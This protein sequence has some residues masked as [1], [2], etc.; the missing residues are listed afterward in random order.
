VVEVCRTCPIPELDDALCATP[1][2]AEALVALSDRWGLDS[3]L[4][5]LFAA[6]DKAC[7]T[8]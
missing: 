2:D 5:R 8:A 7:A 3:P 1:R 6:L 4:N